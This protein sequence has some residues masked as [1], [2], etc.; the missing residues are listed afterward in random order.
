MPELCHTCCDHPEAVKL[1]VYERYR[2]ESCT[3]EIN[4][5]SKKL[6]QL[7]LEKKV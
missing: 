4:I 5:Q 6:K 2:R 1:S 3:E 7:F